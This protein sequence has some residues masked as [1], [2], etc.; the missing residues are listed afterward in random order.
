MVDVSEVLISVDGLH[1]SDLKWFVANHPGSELARLTAGG[2][3]FSNAHTVVP[4]DSEVSMKKTK[5]PIPRGSAFFIF[6]NTNR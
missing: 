5:K 6:S 2:L 1:Q 3:E 4:S